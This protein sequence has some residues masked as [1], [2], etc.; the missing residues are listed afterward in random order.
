MKLQ[1][2]RYIA[3][4][5]NHNLNVSATADALYTSQPGVSKQVRMLED[6][7]GI[8]IFQRSGKHL[9]H[10]TE[11]GEQVIAIANDILNKV[12]CIKSVA[13]EFT[14]P[15][16]GHLRLATTETLAR[17]AL[18]QVI[19]PFLSQYP[20]VCLDM[21]QGSGAYIEDKVI[22]GDV[23]FVITDHPLPVI[24]E[25]L[26]LPCYLCNYSI[27]V[28]ATHPLARAPQLTLAKLAEF[29]LLTYLGSGVGKSPIDMAFEQAGL[30]PRVAFTAIS[31]DVVNTYVAMGLGVGIVATMAIDKSVDSEFV[32]RDASHLFKAS[33]TRIG[34]RRGSF[35]RRYLLDFIH[36]VAPHL[37]RE[38]IEQITLQKEQHLIDR[39]VAD[40]PL[41]VR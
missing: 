40:I 20:K 30:N 13:H 4:V 19:K 24:A 23:D 2:L 8:Q 6:E 39:I 34:F 15:D 3:E 14:C 37:S 28:P 29:P 41:P 17:Y 38:Q 27:V 32:V 7:L 9:T 22:Q 16:Q 18:P 10:V 1:Q 11:A 21:H 33:I 26:L 36:A 12:D 35:L 31:A 25:L 5:V